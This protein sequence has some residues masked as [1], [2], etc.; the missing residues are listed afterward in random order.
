MWGDISLC[1]IV[2]VV[3]GGV[4]CFLFFMATLTACGSSQMKDWI[5]ASAV[6]CAATAATPDPLTHPL[7]HAGDQTFDSAA[8]QAI[9]VGFLTYCATS[10]NSLFWFHFLTIN[11]L[12]H[13]SM[14]LLIICM[15][16][17][18]KCLLSDPLLIFFLMATLVDYGSSWAKD[19]IQAAAVTYATVMA[20]L[21]TLAHCT[22]LG[23]EAAPPQ[24]L[25]PLQLHSFFFFLFSFLTTLWHMEFPRHSCDLCC[26]WATLDLLTYCAGAGD[27]IL[28]WGCG[29]AINPIAPQQELRLLMFVFLGF[30][31]CL[32][33]YWV[34]WVLYMF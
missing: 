22:G 31:V 3:G 26:V 8:T 10:G 14:C 23:I 15:S 25:K 1:F 13:L 29:D 24:Q 33:C 28:T 19:W 18:K 34:V 21:D 30:F 16:C 11:D 12:E 5:P 27:W 6:T 4:F 2:V 9:A 7:Y 17:F 32:F 20:M